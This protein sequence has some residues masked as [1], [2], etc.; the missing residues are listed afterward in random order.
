MSFSFR[1][2]FY[3]EMMKKSRTR[4]LLTSYP[5]FQF[6]S[7]FFDDGPCSLMVKA[8]QKGQLELH[9]FMGR[10]GT[11]LEGRLEGFFHPAFTVGTHHARYIKGLFF[12]SY[13]HD[14]SIAITGLYSCFGSFFVKGRRK[15]NMDLY[16]A[17][18]PTALTTQGRASRATLT[19]TAG[20]LSMTRSSFRAALGTCSAAFFFWERLVER[21]QAPLL[22]GTLS[23]LPKIMDF[24]RFRRKAFMQTV[25]DRLIAAAPTMGSS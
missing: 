4:R 1:Q 21:R 14:S 6:I 23:Y 9:R 3:E 25:K 5:L 2:P 8:E 12:L 22:H 17:Y 13:T 18:G 19:V 24:V 15:Y 11:L 20:S 7:G 16:F 10:H